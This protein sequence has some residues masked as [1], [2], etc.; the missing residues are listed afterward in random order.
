MIKHIIFLLLPF[1]LSCSF[2]TRSGIWT[3]NQDIAQLEKKNQK[4]FKQ[5]IIIE[6]EFNP[7][8]RIKTI[9]SVNKKTKKND[10]TNDL[11]IFEFNSDVRKISKFKFSKI[12]SFDY[13]EPELVSDKNT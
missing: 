11:S 12:E 1:I 5:N 8:L 4:V 3:E 9:S 13:F 2:D 10:L 7:N 6:K